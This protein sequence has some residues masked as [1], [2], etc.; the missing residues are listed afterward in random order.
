MMRQAA[1]Q[2]KI[3]AFSVAPA[4]PERVPQHP[5]GHHAPADD[6]GAPVGS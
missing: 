3:S 4:Q 5:G 1:A 6:L 2:G